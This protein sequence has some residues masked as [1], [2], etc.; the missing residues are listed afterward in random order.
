M[1]FRFRTG[2]QSGDLNTLTQLL[3]SGV[4]IVTDGGGKVGRR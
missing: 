3:A 4:R 2:S 1:P